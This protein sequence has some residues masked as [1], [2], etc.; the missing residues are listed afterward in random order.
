MQQW[1]LRSLQSAKASQKIHEV[2]G[3]GKNTSANNVGNHNI[4]YREQSQ[5]PIQMIIR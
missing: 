4:G 2:S 5:L 1:V 3:G